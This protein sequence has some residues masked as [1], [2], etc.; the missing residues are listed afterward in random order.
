MKQFLY[1]VYGSGGPVA[2]FKASNGFDEGLALSHVG[3]QFDTD[4]SGRPIF[5][6]VVRVYRMDPGVATYVGMA[7]KNGFTYAQAFKSW[8]E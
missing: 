2:Y 7:S 6:R 3:L 5:T 8:G 4:R 1:K